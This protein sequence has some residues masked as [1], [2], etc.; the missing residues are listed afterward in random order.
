M[1]IILGMLLRKLRPLLESLLSEIRSSRTW[2]LLTKIGSWSLLSKPRS[3]L[4]K[5]GSLLL[6]SLL[7]SLLEPLLRS[8]LEPLLRSLLKSLLRSL[9][10][11]LLRSLLKSLLR[12]ILKSSK[13][14]LLLRIKSR[15]SSKSLIGIL[16]STKSKIG[17]ESYNRNWIINV[18][19]LYF[20]I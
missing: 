4:A 8:L 6:E 13:L 10:K 9:L 1:S 18:K 11:S 3:L 5:R 2:T 7:R 12:S 19:I 15:P 20:D 17:L 14:L 16:P